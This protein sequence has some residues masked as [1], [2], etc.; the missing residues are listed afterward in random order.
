MEKGNI[1]K[2]LENFKVTRKIAHK[3]GLT[4][5]NRIEESELKVD[6][7]SVDTVFYEPD[8]TIG[9][10][11]VTSQN[12]NITLN[13]P[14]FDNSSYLD[15]Q[16]TIDSYGQKLNFTNGTYLKPTENIRI[17]YTENIKKTFDYDSTLNSKK[18]VQKEILGYNIKT[19]RKLNN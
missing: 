18:L 5:E 9:V 16:K 13:F 8:E 10:A 17:L 11:Y 6:N 1:N 7:F 4:L 15:T 2:F 12:N 19:I 14:V 3:M